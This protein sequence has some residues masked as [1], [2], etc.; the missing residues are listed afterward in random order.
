[1]MRLSRL[2]RERSVRMWKRFLTSAAPNWNTPL[3]AF[4]LLLLL[5]K[6][7]PFEVLLIHFPVHFMTIT[8]EFHC[9]IAFSFRNSSRHKAGI[10]PRIS[11]TSSGAFQSAKPRIS[12][13][14]RNPGHLKKKNKNSKKP[15]KYILPVWKFGKKSL[16]L[17]NFIFLYAHISLRQLYKLTSRSS[18]S[19]CT[20]SPPYVLG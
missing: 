3:F 6:L 4:W 11:D 17:N 12:G 20:S 8:N 18:I 1:M 16:K 7:F 10:S 19:L 5:Q 13:T 14:I 9:I 15:K 2:L